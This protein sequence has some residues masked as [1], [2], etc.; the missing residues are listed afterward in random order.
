MRSRPVGHRCFVALLCLVGIYGGVLRAQWTHTDTVQLA[1]YMEAYA[2]KMKALR[3]YE[4][5]TT[6][7]S[8]RNAT[9]AVAQEVGHSTVWRVGDRIKAEHLGVLTFQDAT[10]HVLVDPE[11]RMIYLAKPE[12]A[13]T[14]VDA[15]MRSIMFKAIT[16]VELQRSVAGTRFRLHFPKAAQYSII[17]LAFDPQGWLRSLAMT[18][19][20]PIAVD[21]G[22]PLTAMVLPK[23]VCT[24]DVP[25]AVVKKV[26]VD[27]AQVITRRSNSIVGVGP[28]AGYEVF[29]TRSE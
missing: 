13:R 9:D 21:P 17:E 15:Y 10:L 1:K 7:S 26:N 27:M 29:D 12:E 22:N 14:A 28:Y 20:E 2:Q 24:L 4:M 11:E 16:A 5:R 18:W 25:A 23:V 3:D 6:I 8:Y 19:S